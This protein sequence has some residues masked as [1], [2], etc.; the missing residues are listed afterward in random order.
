MKSW[1]SNSFPDLC[2]KNFYEG[3]RVCVEGPNL[4]RAAFLPCSSGKSE[5]SFRLKIYLGR[6]TRWASMEREQLRELSYH[7]KYYSKEASHRTQFFKKIKLRLDI[8]HSCVL[9]FKEKQVANSSL[10]LVLRIFLSLCNIHRG[11]S[12]RLAK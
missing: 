7:M 4:G 6:N 1:S 9:T 3:I 2:P 11:T 12:T 5:K 10:Y 8:V